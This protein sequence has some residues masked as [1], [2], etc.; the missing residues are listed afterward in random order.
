MRRLPASCHRGPLL[1]WRVLRSLR[2]GARGRCEGRLRRET[3]DNRKDCAR[4]RTAAGFLP[5]GRTRGGSGGHWKRIRSRKDGIDPHPIR[6]ARCSPHLRCQHPARDGGPVVAS[7]YPPQ[8]RKETHLA[9][10]RCPRGVRKFPAGCSHCRSGH[11]MRSQPTPRCLGPAHARALRRCLL[12]S[13]LRDDTGGN[14]GVL[15]KSTAGLPS[16]KRSGLGAPCPAAARL[17]KGNLDFQWRFI[18]FSRR[19]FWIS[20]PRR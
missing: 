12:D 19:N 20:V 1:D 5:R 15:R 13:V 18:V 8:H 3:P 10:Q 16:D 4:S 7:G 6:R 2:R 14:R 17:M 11:R 9:L